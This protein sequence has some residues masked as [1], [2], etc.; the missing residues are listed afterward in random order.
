MTAPDDRRCRDASGRLMSEAEVIE[1]NARG[2]RDA[3]RVADIIE[4]GLRDDVPTIRSALDALEDTDVP[5]LIHYVVTM[6]KQI[7]CRPGRDAHWIA[8]SMREEALLRLG[9]PFH[10]LRESDE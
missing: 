9:L 3:L 6:M 8:N 2:S 5:D 1:H 10:A 7:G 4:A